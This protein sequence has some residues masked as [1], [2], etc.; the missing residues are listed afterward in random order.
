MKISSPSFNERGTI[1]VKYTCDGE[2][3]SPSLDIMDIP[4]RAVSLAII[5]DDPE[6]LIG[7]WTYWLG[8]NIPIK[9]H[10]K[11]G[12][13]PPGQGANDFG[14]VAYGGPCP[15]R[16]THRYYFRVYALDIPIYAPLGADRQVLEADMNGHIL[17][18]ATLSAYYTRK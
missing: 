10:L 4:P 14:Q 1:P 3:I 11:E 5:M 6:A 15:R 13:M 8:W 9:H 18:T 12:Y 2:N 7:T 17:A 16:G